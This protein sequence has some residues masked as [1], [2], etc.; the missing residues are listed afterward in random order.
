MTI[1]TKKQLLK[2]LNFLD[3]SFQKNIHNKAVIEE[4]PRKPRMLASGMNWQN[5]FK[6]T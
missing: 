5:N 2:R 4:L 3:D 1:K 6:K